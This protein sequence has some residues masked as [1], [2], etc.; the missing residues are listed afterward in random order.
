[1]RFG[2]VCSGIG[3]PEVAWHPLGWRGAWAAEIE[4][5]CCAVLAHHWPGIPNHGDLTQLDTGKLDA[6]DVLCGGTPC[7]GFSVA[8]LRGG[9]DDARSQL[10]WHFL[11]VARELR[12]R[13]LV[14]ENVPGVFTTDEG[15]DFGAVLGAM[16]ELGYGVF[17]RVLDAQYFG[18]AQ[19][20]ERVFAVGYLG[21]WRPAAAVLLER[22]CLRGDPAPSRK[23]GQ[24]VA[25]DV[26]PSLTGSGRGVS[27][28]GESRGQDPVVA[29]T[30]HGTDKTQKVASETDIAGIL[31]TKP[32]GSIENSSTTVV[33]RALNAKGGIGRL[34]GESE[35]F[36]PCVAGTLKRNNGGGGFVSDPSETF[37]P[38][39]F[40]EAQTGVRE[41][42]AAGSLRAN[43]PGHDP[44]GTRVRIGMAVRRLTPRE[45]ERLQGF[46]DDYTA[47][48]YRG[49]PAKDGP[50]YRA[51]GNSMAVPVMRWIGERISMVDRLMRGVA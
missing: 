48:T 49:K 14:W 30:I 20:R 50:R 41:Y 40:Q 3:A 22:S 10:V 36:V 27:R 5:F 45:C 11:R 24:G 44:V 28:T 46:P 9:L 7:Q 33:A 16:E 51:L 19:R 47:I 2:T 29:Y 23:A 39:A 31:R 6:I 12:P 25:G 37:V 17:S 35:T 34:D 1:V 21:D 13:W 43:G 8:G 26:A 32:P 18:L 15:R 4:P 42:D 38:V